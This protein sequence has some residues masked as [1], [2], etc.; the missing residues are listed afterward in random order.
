MARR[1]EGVTGGDRFATLAAMPS[2]RSPL[3]LA[4]LTS[5][6]LGAC[7][8]PEE[9][10]QAGPAPVVVD[11]E[12]S[13]EVLPAPALDRAA[14]LD[15]VADAAS[16]HAAGSDDSKAQAALDGRRFA[17]KLRFGCG[18]PAGEASTDALRWRVK[19]D[20]SLE[21]TATPDLSLDAPELTGAL[22]QT[23]EAVEGFWIA[24]PWLFSDAC[25]AMPKAAQ[26]PTA[27]AAAAER[28][29]GIAQYYTPEGSRTER[30]SGRAYVSLAPIEPGAPLPQD[31]FFL[32]LEGRLQAW[33]GGKPIHCS[34]SVAGARPAC[35]V[36]VRFDRVAF[37]RPGDG[38]VIDE[39][40][41]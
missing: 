9:A 15:A 7:E 25:P 19:S 23:V 31:G 33:P 20:E 5:A 21:I 37:T 30:R 36:S 10:N 17:V 6:L 8:A 27:A 24:R 12:P 35:I 11:K 22:T 41:N 26:A 28:S 14:L 38:E 2:A 3:R 1:S 13:P 34:T 29:V 40:T 32:L 18:G 4:I 16:A 39:W